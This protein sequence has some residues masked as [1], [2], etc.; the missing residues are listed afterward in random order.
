MEISRTGFLTL[1]LNSPMTL[2]Q[3]F[4]LYSLTH[5]LIKEVVL[6][7]YHFVSDKHL[8][9]VDIRGT[10]SARQKLF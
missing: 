10:I 5:S 6:R 8:I 1:F 4:Y 2:S 3:L 7:Y 9:I